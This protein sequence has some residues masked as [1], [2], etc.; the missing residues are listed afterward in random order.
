M[1]SS[2]VRF[3]HTGAVEGTLK[4]CLP[5]YHLAEHGE[6]SALISFRLTEVVSLF[7]LAEAEF[8]LV[9]MPLVLRCKAAQDMP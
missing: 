7:I 9:F 6:E 2:G 4:T 5:E 1:P 8:T 3:L